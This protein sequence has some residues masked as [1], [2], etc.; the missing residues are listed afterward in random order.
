MRKAVDA[1]SNTA[2]IT[3]NSREREAALLINAAVKL[4]QVK[5]QDLAD[6]AALDDA[7]TYN[8][9]LWTIFVGSMAETDNPLP[10]EVRNNVASLGVFI[11]K[12]T[13]EVQSRPSADKLNALI[14]INKEIAAGLRDQ[15]A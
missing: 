7:L 14:S 12:Q 9:K 1:Y 15:A 5:D 8:Q 10:L 4:Q 3:V 11:F 2:K 13:L 6:R